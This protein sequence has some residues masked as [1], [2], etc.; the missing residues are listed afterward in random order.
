MRPI[1]VSQCYFILTSTPWSNVCYCNVNPFK[2]SRKPYLV[3]VYN[4]PLYAHIHNKS[5]KS[6]FAEAE[7]PR[8]VKYPRSV[9]D[10]T[11]L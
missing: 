6:V 10:R 5:H 9:L 11:V 1:Y 2:R 8:L 3:F 4:A 7:P